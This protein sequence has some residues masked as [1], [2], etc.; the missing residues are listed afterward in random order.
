M[1]R[2]PASGCCT[3]WR[4]R[5][6]KKSYR[7][8]GCGRWCPRLGWRRLKAAT[9][10]ATAVASAPLGNG[11]RP[12]PRG[13]RLPAWRSDPRAGAPTVARGS[14][15]GVAGHA[16]GRRGETR[17]WPGRGDGG[18]KS[19]AHCPNMLPGGEGG[20]RRTVRARDHEVCPGT[21]SAVTRESHQSNARA[22]TP[23]ERTLT[24][25]VSVFLGQQEVKVAQCD[26]R[27]RFHMCLM[28][29]ASPAGVAGSQPAFDG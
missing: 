20:A 21:A 3:R 22:K 24:K 5:P 19:R 27:E 9:S 26:R 28:C 2:W 14:R 15:G 13:A 23:R 7:H 17:N 16:A 6:R 29:R 25:G 11:G 12:G 8:P 4:R 10:S 1:R 18:C